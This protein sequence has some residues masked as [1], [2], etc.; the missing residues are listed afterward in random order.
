MLTLIG[1][2]IFNDLLKIQM[3]WLSIEDAD[4]SY[5]IQINE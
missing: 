2:G 4:S 3:V 1:N 5:S